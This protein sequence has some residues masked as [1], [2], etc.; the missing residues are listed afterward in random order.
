[1]VFLFGLMSAT[2]WIAAQ[3]FSL[4]MLVAFT[5]VP[6]AIVLY[7]ITLQTDEESNKAGL[8]PSVVLQ[9]DP[10]IV[11]GPEQSIDED[12]DDATD[13]S[14]RRSKT[15]SMQP[16]RTRYYSA[17]LAVS[18][19]RTEYRN[20]CIYIILLSLSF[21]HH[22]YAIPSSCLQIIIVIMHSPRG[23]ITVDSI[24]SNIFCL[25]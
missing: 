6:T 4:A 5:T 7:S 21:S 2:T 24:L 15:P 23:L 10:I 16:P 25:R 19:V 14:Q 18:M 9:V 12:H 20:C 3:H 8:P 22:M 11:V 1:V 17:L 13:L